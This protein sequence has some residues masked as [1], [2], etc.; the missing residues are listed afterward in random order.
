MKSLKNLMTENPTCVTPE[1]TVREAAKLMESQDVGSL[2]VVQ[3]E[4]SR[5]LVAMVTDRDLAIRILAQG[6]DGNSLVRDAMSSNVQSCKVDDS[7]DEVEKVMS[8][9]QVRRV[10]IVDEQNR[11]IGM[12]AQA[13]LAR[14][15]KA[16]GEKDFG[17]VIEKI[18]EP[19]GVR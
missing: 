9:H 15:R 19:A 11:V 18:S 2:P 7:L 17:K 4:S 12:V 6:K 5:R 10:P 3:D 8:R 14:E 16:V 1:A 13:D